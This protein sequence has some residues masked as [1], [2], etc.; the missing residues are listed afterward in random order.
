MSS[1][2]VARR[3]AQ[4]LEHA[5]RDR[6]VASVEHLGAQV[7]EHRGHLGSGVRGDGGVELVEPDGDVLHLASVDLR[8]QCRQLREGQRLRARLRIELCAAG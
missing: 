1:A 2:C 4:R 7:G 8:Q 3:S 6:L 5:R